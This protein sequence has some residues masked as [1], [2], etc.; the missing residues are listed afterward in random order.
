MKLSIS[1]HDLLTLI[2]FSVKILRNIIIFRGLFKTTLMRIL[3]IIDDALKLYFM[4]IDYLD[5]S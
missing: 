4:P 1:E 3:K 2:N 5:S